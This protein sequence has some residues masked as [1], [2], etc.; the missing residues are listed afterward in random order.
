MAAMIYGEATVLLAHSNSCG[1]REYLCECVDDGHGDWL[2]WVG[3]HHHSYQTNSYLWCV[4]GMLL[5]S[6]GELGYTSTEEK[7][8]LSEIVQSLKAFEAWVVPS[9]TAQFVKLNYVTSM[10]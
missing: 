10:P 8:Q 9:N 7:Q 3:K 1:R 5:M 4:C 6:T 2:Q